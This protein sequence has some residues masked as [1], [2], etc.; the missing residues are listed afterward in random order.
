MERDYVKGILK[1][2]RPK[3]RLGQHFL[4]NEVIADRIVQAAEI[5]PQ[6]ACLEIG[7]GLGVLTCR[8]V[9]LSRIT[10]AVEIDEV[11]CQILQQRISSTS[12]N[13]ILIKSDI[14]R[15]NLFDLVIRYGVDKFKVI[16]NLP[17]RVTTPIIFWL[18]QNRLYIK[19]AI[20]T[21]QKEVAERLIAEPGSKEYGSITPK[22]HYYA[23]INSVHKISRNNFL[24]VPE[25]DSI[26]IKIDF[27]P[28]PRFPV[29]DENHLFDLIDKSF[30][31][32]RKMLKNCL[33]S[34]FGL[35]D[36]ELE[37]LEIASGIDLRR[38][39]ETLSLREFILLSKQ[40]RELRSR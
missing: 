27:L 12:K 17:Y 13:L 20:L 9:P 8:I 31:N 2:F 14:L 19:N 16:S 32:R 24:P 35:E 33:R 28:K 38:R 22:V 1:K 37:E 23:T 4:I 25:V 40:I 11:L 7:A 5:S 18:V 36:K 26:L 29:D 10:I 34:N 21:L 39:G 6:D 3:K 15:L 30:Q